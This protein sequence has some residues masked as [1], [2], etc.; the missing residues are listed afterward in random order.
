MNERN[1]GKGVSILHSLILYLVQNTHKMVNA[2][3]LAGSALGKRKK[4]KWK[5]KGT[6]CKL[7]YYFLIKVSVSILESYV[8]AELMNA[9][10]IF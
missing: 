8:L 5:E 1:G 9:V 6:S 10:L 2:V 4:E 3:Y 7:L